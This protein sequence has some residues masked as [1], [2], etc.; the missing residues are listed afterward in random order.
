M[1]AGTDLIIK[2]RKMKKDAILLYAGAGALPAPRRSG[3]AY[4]RLSGFA[5]GKIY[6]KHRDNEGDEKSRAFF[7]P[8]SYLSTVCNHCTACIRVR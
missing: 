5:E 7:I 4:I 1:I 3:Q 8:C 2:Q 6:V